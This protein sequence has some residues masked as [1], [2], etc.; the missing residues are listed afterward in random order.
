MKIVML[1]LWITQAASQ[2]PEPPEPVC[3][4]MD[5]GMVCSLGETAKP[6]RPNPYAKCKEIEPGIKACY[7]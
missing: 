3:T 6:K 2:T 7:A 5:G 1:A 4:E